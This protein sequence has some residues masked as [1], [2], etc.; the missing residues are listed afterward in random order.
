MGIPRLNISNIT[1]AATASD[2]SALAAV[3]EDV[4]G[5]S[6]FLEGSIS[7]AGQRTANQDY[8]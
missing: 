3:H 7:S 1:Q 4:L 6:S 5:E 2:Q 8:H